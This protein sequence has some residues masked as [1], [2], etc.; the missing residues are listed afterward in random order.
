MTALAI[1]ALAASVAGASFTIQKGLFAIA[2][3]IK[4][5]NV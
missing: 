5:G 3:A 4:E 1:F 2:D